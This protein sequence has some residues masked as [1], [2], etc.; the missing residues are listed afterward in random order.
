MIL[1]NIFKE[2]I[3]PELKRIVEKV[4]KSER[5]SVDD[6]IILFEK[7]D[8]GLLGVLANYVREKLHGDRTYFNRNFHIEPTNICIYDC[9]F[10]SYKAK[11]NDADA[12]DFSVQQMLDIVKSYDDK[13]ITEVHI[14]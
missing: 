10:C 6:G 13:P 2:N 8:L 4:E 12:W 5:I 11:I 9:E 14:V 3:S 7:A 1:D